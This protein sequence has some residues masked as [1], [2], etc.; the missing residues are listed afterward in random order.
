MTGL[1]RNDQLQFLHSGV[2]LQAR[3]RGKEFQWM[4]Q[5]WSRCSD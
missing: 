1:S 4:I 2:Y 3:F 5:R